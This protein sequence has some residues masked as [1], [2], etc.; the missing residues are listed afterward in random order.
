LEDLKNGMLTVKF[1][2]IIL[3]DS[4]TNEAESHG[5]FIYPIQ[6]RKDL[7]GGERIENSVWITFD[8]EKPILTNIVVNTIN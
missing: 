4:T 2:N 3:P 7:K 8:Y 1:K 6:P 5:L